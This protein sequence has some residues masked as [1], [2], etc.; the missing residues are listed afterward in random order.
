MYVETFRPNNLEDVIGHLEAKES[1][2]KYLLTP[3]F[4]KAIMLTGPPGIGKTT[5]ALSAAKTFNFNPLEINA[6]RSIR[7]YEDVMKIR[8][9]CRSA[10]NIHSFI[11]GDTK[12]K[13]CVILDEIDGSDP[14][15]QA[16]IVEWIKDS[17]RKVPIICTGNE[18]PTIFKRN[19]D[20]IEIIR[21]FPPRSVDIQKLFN[22]D[23]SKQLV[24][25]QHDIRKLLHRIQYGESDIL[26][27]VLVPPTGIPIEKSFQMRQSM[28]DLPDSLHEYRADI[29]DNEHS[30]KTKLKCKID[31]K[32]DHIDE[33]LNRQKKSG[34]DKSRNYQ[35]KKN[36][37]K[38]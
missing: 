27:K 3:G 31:E 34:L 14:H 30:L 12:Q 13:T 38:N 7:S 21:C 17:S 5:L 1:L 6:S 29:L 19:S 4:S 23:V 36:L 24:E 35:K 33:S 8:D 9:S 20:H 16:K 25:C 10:I 2:K 11:K 37:P 22:M 28:F 15:A 18:L 26:P 32:N